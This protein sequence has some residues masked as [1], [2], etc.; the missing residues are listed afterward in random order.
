MKIP[1]DDGSSAQSGWASRRLSGTV[2]RPKI[3]SQRQ[4]PD[5][6]K[7]IPVNR[8]DH[9]PDFT[10]PPL[11]EVVLGIQFNAVQGFMQIHAHDVWDLFR[12]EYPLVE[13]M[14][15]LPPQFETFGRPG[16]P[17]I[18][19]FPMSQGSRFWFLSPDKDELLQFQS[20]KFLH[21]WRQVEDQKN[22]YPR[23]EA[24]YDKFSHELR[25]LHRHFLERFHDSMTVTQCEVTYINHIYVAD[26]HKNPSKWLN[27]INYARDADDFNVAFR[28]VIADD[29]GRPQGRLLCDAGMA[30]NAQGDRLILLTITARGA[31]SAPDWKSALEFIRR[32]REMVVSLFADV[33]TDFAHGIW[34][35]SK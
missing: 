18:N 12:K 15:L 19:F 32:G 13:E 1:E 8:P 28:E 24:V 3:L 20:D 25:L 2:A 10:K 9:L 16:A 14:P 7:A 27:F 35:R 17:Q 30:A 11:N 5:C 34:D 22:S 4:P 26:E 31:P 29:A 33:T 23:F 21:N 6:R